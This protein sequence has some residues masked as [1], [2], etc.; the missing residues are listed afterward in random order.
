[1]ADLVE[2]VEVAFILVTDTMPLTSGLST[3]KADNLL[4][5]FLHFLLTGFTHMTRNP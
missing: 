3:R 5:V 1:M 2:V 4:Y